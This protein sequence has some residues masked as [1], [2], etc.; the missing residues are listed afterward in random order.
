MKILALALNV[1]RLSVPNSAPG[2]ALYSGCHP[3]TGK[4]EG[5]ALVFRGERA[6]SL[7]TAR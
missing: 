6:R 7:L 5:R 1:V 3:A 2:K 4:G